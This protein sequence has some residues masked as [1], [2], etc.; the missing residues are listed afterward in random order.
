MNAEI[1]DYF[2][3]AGVGR[4]GTFIAVDH[5]LQHLKTSTYVDIFGL[6]HAMRL[7]R[8]FMVQTEVHMQLCL[9]LNLPCFLDKNSKL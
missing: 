1:I 6:I 9:H 8:K 2:C 7:Q 4:T 3:S 5:L